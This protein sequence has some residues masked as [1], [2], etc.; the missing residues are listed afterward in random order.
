MKIY[1]I[2]LHLG[3]FIHL[4]KM[5]DVVGKNIKTYNRIPS[6]KTLTVALEL[7]CIDLIVDPCFPIKWIACDDDTNSLTEQNAAQAAAAPAVSPSLGDRP[8]IR[9]NTLTTA[10]IAG[11]NCASGSSFPDISTWNEIHTQITKRKLAYCFS[12]WYEVQCITQ[13]CWVLTNAERIQIIQIV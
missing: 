11:D 13:Q 6:D 2:L 12:Q 7:S 4:R 8:D 1:V 5:L 10:S 9:L 3:W